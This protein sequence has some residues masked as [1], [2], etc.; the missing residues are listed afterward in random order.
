[1]RD[2]TI[3]GE[4]ILAA[5]PAL[6]PVARLVRSTHERWDGRGYPDG[7]AG[8]DIPLGAR[9][10]FACDALNAMTSPRSYRETL[11]MSEAVE[12]LR[13]CAGA[14]FDALVVDVLCGEVLSESSVAETAGAR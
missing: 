10:I 13:F 11:S 6:R 14:Q 3:L 5:A 7:L 2:H 9:I 4:R 12:E 8:E 1:M